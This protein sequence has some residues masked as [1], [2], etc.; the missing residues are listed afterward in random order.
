MHISQIESIQS[1]EELPK[2]IVAIIRGAAK[3]PGECVSG[4][5]HYDRFNRMPNGTMITTTRVISHVENVIT[6]KTGNKYLVEWV[7][8]ENPPVFEVAS[9]ETANG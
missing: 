8:Q 5:I 7:D 4:A 3:W 9:T 2:G 6:T 1:A